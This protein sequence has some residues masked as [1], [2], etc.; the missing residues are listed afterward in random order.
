MWVLGVEKRREVNSITQPTSWKLAPTA[1]P[2]RNASKPLPSF[3]SQIK[4]PG[5]E[6]NY[7]NITSLQ[8]KA[9]SS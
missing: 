4:D 7:P 9:Q 3:V 5:E 8:R 2:E 1:V 6:D